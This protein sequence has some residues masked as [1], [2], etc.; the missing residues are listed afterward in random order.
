MIVCH[1]M[2]SVLLSSQPFPLLW[3]IISL[4]ITELW[5]SSPVFL[6]YPPDATHPCHATYWGRRWIL[7]GWMA[8]LSYG[9]SLPL[10]AKRHSTQVEP[11]KI[12]LTQCVTVCVKYQ[13]Y[14][15]GILWP[16]CSD[17]VYP[18]WSDILSLVSRQ[19]AVLS[20]EWC[21]FLSTVYNNTI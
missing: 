9:K 8:F 17:P 21:F 2:F 7:T 6:P 20:Y 5:N 14:C 1:A 11:V 10:S 12:R 3:I 16:S 13:R 19:W 4:V 18:C 15:F